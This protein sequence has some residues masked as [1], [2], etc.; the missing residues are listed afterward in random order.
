MNK[1]CAI[2]NCFGDS[3]ELLPYSLNCL[4]GEV[5]EIIFVTQDISNYGEKIEYQLFSEGFLENLFSHTVFTYAK[6]TPDLK[7]TGMVNETAKRNLGL[8]IAKEHGC[9]HFLN[10]D[11]DELFEDFGKAKDA[12]ISAG[13]NGSV[14]KMITY[15]KRPTLRLKNPEGYYVPFIHKLFLHTK[16]GNTPYPFYVDP[17]R[18]VNE[19]DVIELSHFMHHFSYVR[20]DIGLKVRNSSARDNILKGTILKDYYSLGLGEGSYI[21]DFGQHLTV[22]PNLFYI[23]I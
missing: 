11:C 13:H 23:E 3:T 7:K 12:Y 1:L 8:E 19:T 9:T 22:V 14:S 17:T 10:I 5:D 6:F 4:V 21:K 15:F 2:Y 20:R 16:A 18:R